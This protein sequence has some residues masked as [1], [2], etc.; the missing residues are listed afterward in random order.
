MNTSKFSQWLSAQMEERGWSQADLAK[1]AGLTRTAVSQYINKKR[2]KPEPESMVAIARAFQ[3]SPI[4]VFRV[5]DLL[6][7]GPSDD[8]TLDDWKEILPRLSERDQKIL[9]NMALNMLQ[10]DERTKGTP[11]SKPATSTE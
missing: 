1:A 2:T 11:V 6:P 10:T 5:A 4:E 7:P 8:V 9:K 3:V